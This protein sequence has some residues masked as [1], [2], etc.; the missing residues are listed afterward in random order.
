MRVT[1]TAGQNIAAGEIVAV[2]SD[3]LAYRSRPTGFSTALAGTATNFVTTAL[4]TLGKMYWF[5]TTDE[6]TK[7]FLGVDTDDAPDSFMAL[8]AT[9]DASYESIASS[10]AVAH[11]STTL[12]RDAY[13]TVQH[14]S[15]SQVT[16][17]IS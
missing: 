11:A 8:R 1:V 2:E 14:N 6:Q 12:I 16:V 4:G 7:C 13:D 17:L 15:S 9:V 10:A 3:G 5:E